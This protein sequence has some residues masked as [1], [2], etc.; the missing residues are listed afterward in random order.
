MAFAT[1]A[2]SMALAADFTG[3]W[4]NSDTSARGMV[5]FTITPGTFHGYGSCTPTPCDWGT[6]PLV[7]YSKS[8]TDSNDIAGI[9]QYNSGFS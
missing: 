2:P 7:L 6:T 9:A 1:V 3:T 8:V 4:V 5:K